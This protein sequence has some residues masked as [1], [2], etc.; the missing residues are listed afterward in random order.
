MPTPNGVNYLLQFLKHFFQFPNCQKQESKVD[1]HP[2]CPY[3][4]FTLP[5]AV[6]IVVITLPICL[7]KGYNAR[8]SAA[9]IAFSYDIFGK[10]HPKL[11]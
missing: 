10:S 4:C 2:I 3:I 7:G 9:N 1:V 5:Y 11:S 8:K 6:N